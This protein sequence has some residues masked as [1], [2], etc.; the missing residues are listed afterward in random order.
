VFNIRKDDPRFFTDPKA[1]NTNAHYLRTLPV[2][3][4]LP[5]VR[6]QLE[7]TGLW[8]PAWEKEDA[9]WFSN[10][11][12][13]IRARFHTTVDFVE[14]GRAYFSDRFPT[15]SKALE[16]NIL[17]HDVLKKWL[18]EMAHRISEIPDFTRPSIESVLEEVLKEM[19]VKP[20]VLMNAVRTA[21]TGQP[22]GPEFFDFL[23]AIGQR[24]VVRRLRQAAQWFKNV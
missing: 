14:L 22:K 7:K 11:V 8:D 1:I 16:K 15:D 6:E 20:G 24:E 18:P 23:L 2:Q 10:T 5:A 9:R 21:V 19:G 12:D 17:K 3:E 13:L 4:I